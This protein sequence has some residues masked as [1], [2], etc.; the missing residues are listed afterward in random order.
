MRKLI[1][2]LVLLLLYLDGF[3]ALKLFSANRARIINFR[4]VF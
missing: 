2:A 4:A 3:Y 1:E